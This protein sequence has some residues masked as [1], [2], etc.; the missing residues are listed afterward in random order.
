[1]LVLSNLFWLSI[2]LSSFSPRLLWPVAGSF[3]P[4]THLDTG[5]IP[6]MLSLFHARAR[7]IFIYPHYIHA[8]YG[9]YFLNGEGAG[10]E[11]GK[12]SLYKEEKRG[13][14][15]GKAFVY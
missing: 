10:E 15:R 7:R 3:I 14:A 11:P 4:L 12:E 5:P 9:L 2:A 13:R 6:E 8:F 1:M